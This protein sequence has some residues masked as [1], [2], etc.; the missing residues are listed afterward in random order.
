MLAVLAVHTVLAVIAELALLAVPVL[1]VTCQSSGKAKWWQ[2]IQWR[3]RRLWQRGSRTEGGMA[4]A[5]AR[6]TSV[7]TRAGKKGPERR[8]RNTSVLTSR[9]KGV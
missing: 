1:A 6:K 4:E 7:L 5:K 9:T 2:A 8:G 3:G